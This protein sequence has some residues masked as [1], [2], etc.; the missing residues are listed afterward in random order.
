VD[1]FLSRSQPDSNSNGIQP[2]FLSEVIL[3]LVDQRTSLSV[4]HVRDQT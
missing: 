1:V 2:N 4:L 3:N